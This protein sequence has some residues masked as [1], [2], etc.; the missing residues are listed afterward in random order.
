MDKHEIKKLWLNKKWVESDTFHIYI[1]NPFCLTECK[2]CIH[3]GHKIRINDT[4]Y[5]KY[6]EDYLPS[7]IEFW[8]DVFNC[9]PVKSIY[10]GGG[11]SSIMTLDT[12][13]NIFGLIPNFENIPN[14]IFECNPSL[15]SKSKI[16][17]LNKNKFSYVSFGVQ[18]FNERILKNQNRIP[19]SIKKL[20]ENVLS[21]EKNGCFVNVD[22]MSFIDTE[23]ERDLDVLHHDIYKLISEVNPAMITIYPARQALV[24]KMPA[25]YCTREG[26]ETPQK[27]RT[28]DEQNIRNFKLIEKLRKVLIEVNSKTE[29][30]LVN[31]AMD[32]REF[33]S[34]DAILK[35]AYRNYTLTR[36][37]KEIYRNIKCYNSSGNNR[38][39]ISQNTLGI[40]S[41][42]GECDP[43]YSYMN[44]DLYYIESNKNWVVNY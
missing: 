31:Q 25:Y 15:M 12:M 24:Q 44:R 28:E 21:L 9:Y 34:R 10:F 36:L 22:L 27:V 11:T 37:P 42:M 6:Y 18:T 40:G 7:L 8:T 43:S 35:N 20:K 3:R 30:T 13:I 32:K 41:F 26:L 23:S 16:D 39:P 33:L 17:L 29:Y 2:F 5:K 38:H 4:T 19:I 1:H 14:K